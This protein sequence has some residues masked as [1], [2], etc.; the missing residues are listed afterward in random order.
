MRGLSIGCLDATT[1]GDT[2]LVNEVAAATITGGPSS[3]T[4]TVILCLP[5]AALSAASVIGDILAPSLLRHHVAALVLLT[6]R[7]AYLAAAASQI[8]LPLFM[9]IG[10]ARLA[11]GD[12]FHFL[13]GRLHGQK[14]V[15]RLGRF[16]PGIARTARRAGIPAVAAFPTGK[17]LLAAGAGGLAAMPV[18]LADLAGTAVRIVVVWAAARSLPAGTALIV[19]VSW[20]APVAVVATTLAFV[21]HARWR[22]S[23]G[24]ARGRSASGM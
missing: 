16:S 21:C 5:I 7:T 6:P 8:P 4:R 15:D 18:A 19:R 1:A 24:E 23:R 14:S 17:T 12:P 2:P 10:L 13:L 11:V 9:I 22:A 3:R 20:V